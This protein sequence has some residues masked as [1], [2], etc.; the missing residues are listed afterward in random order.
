MQ[1][2]EGGLADAIRRGSFDEM[3]RYDG[4]HAPGAESGY[5]AFLR[6][7]GH[8]SADPWTDHV[9]SAIDASVHIVSG[10]TM[11]HIHRRRVCWRRILRRLA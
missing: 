10:R 1:L 7:Q 4:H 9:I 8:G 11:R 2:N 5:T 6:S 3:D